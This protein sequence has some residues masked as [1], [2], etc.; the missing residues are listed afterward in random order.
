[1]HTQPARHLR[2]LILATLVALAAALVVPSP[3]W[4][5]DDTEDRMNDGH[6]ALDRSQYRTAVERFQQAA[7]LAEVAKLEHQRA[8]ALYWQAFALQRIGGKQELQR[9]AATLLELRSEF[10]EQELQAETRA[11][12]ARVKSELAQQGDARA[13]RE[14]AEMLEVME[15]DDSYNEEKLIALQALTN[16]NPE[17]A[18]PILRKVLADR[19]PGSEGL[20][21]EAVFLVSQGGAEG[22]EE[23]MM[24]LALNDPDPEVRSQAVFWLG[25]TGSETALSFFRQ[26][27]T[28]EDDP[29]ILEQAVFAISQMDSEEAGAVL[30]DL[31]RDPSQ[32]A[33][34]REMALFGLGHNGSAEDRAFLRELYTGLDDPQLKEQ[35]LH[36]V[37]QHEDPES[38]DWLV[39]IALDP[40]EDMESRKMALFWA[41]QQGL[42]PL[43]RLDEVYTSI[44]DREMREQIIFVLSQDGSDEAVQRLMTIAR[45]E[46]DPQLRKD[47]IFWIGQSDAEGAEEFLLEIINR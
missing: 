46:E 34:I 12:A 39:S 26:L 31:A 40:D 25:Q 11:L 13:A 20:R 27:I 8:E 21:R 9:A 32:D 16:M 24:D 30:R 42:L 6:A 18:L 47:A 2:S 3:V 38:G 36:A 35:V 41:G 10:L 4:A 1:M 33:E 28:T 15:A 44:D 22:A 5:Q 29:E 23:L 45:E 37:A 43:A 19:E 17:R 7:E 14:L